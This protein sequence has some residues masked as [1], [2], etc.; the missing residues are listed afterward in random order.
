MRRRLAS[1]HRTRSH[2]T[3]RQPYSVAKP[4]LNSVPLD[5]TVTTRTRHAR[6]TGAVSLTVREHKHVKCNGS[7]CK[8]AI[9]EQSGQASAPF[10]LRKSSRRSLVRP[11]PHRTGLPVDDDHLAA[12]SPLAQAESPGLRASPAADDTPAPSLG[13][14]IAW[15]CRS[16]VQ[17]RRQRNLSTTKHVKYNSPECKVAIRQGP[18]YDLYSATRPSR[19]CGTAH[20]KNTKSNQRGVVHPDRATVQRAEPSRLP[21]G[22]IR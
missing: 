13:D 18:S 12:R 22:L 17:A 5:T 10:R 21:F 2:Q 11:A 6:L 8:V 15:T 4:M 9:Q 3:T 16:W 1:T 19:S 7:E 14:C 20:R